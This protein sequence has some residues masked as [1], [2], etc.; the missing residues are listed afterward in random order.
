MRA[1]AAGLVTAALVVV[2][3]IAESLTERYVSDHSRLAGS[4]IELTI[5]ALAALA[6]S[7]LHKRVESLIEAAFTKRR[8]EAREALSHLKRELTSFNDAQQVL[9]RVVEA[10]DRH[11]S[12][13]GCAIYLRRGAYAVEASSF[14]V[15]VTNLEPDDPLV[16]RLRSSSASANPHAINS[17]ASGELAFPMMAGGELIGILTLTPNRI[18]YDAEDRHAL[19]ALA[20]AAGLALIALDPQ[21]RPQGQP[22]NNLP[23]MLTSFVGRENEVTEI[24]A[25]LQ[26]H[27]LMTLMGAGGVGKTRAALRVAANLLDGFADGVWLVELAPISDPSLVAGAVAQTLNAPQSS[28]RPPID[29]L[30][31]YLKRKRLLLLLD[32]CEH[33]INDARTVAAAVLHGCPEVHIL[34]TSREH[35]NVSGEEVYRMPSLSV[36]PEGQALPTQEVLTFGAALLFA[37]RA[38]AV[39]KRFAI[40]DENAPYVAEISRRLDGIPLAIEL[41]A[42]R[43]NVLSPKQL[44]QKLDERFRVLTGGDRSALPRHQTMRALIDWSYDLLSD[45]ERALFRKLSIFAGGFTL[46][47]ARAVCDVDAVDEIATL[48]LLSSLVDKSLVQA[49]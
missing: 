40:T 22:R 12:A 42:A 23:H 8:R 16:I 39:D 28:D 9:R 32:N 18:D 34:A 33:V 21:L 2:F 25:L 5:V 6:F 14:D 37:D 4:A 13:A 7:P 20:E 31:G 46:E 41:A 38:F 30:V 24:Q 47:S 10:V 26:Q 43:V 49:Q 35:L 3:A 19:D 29:T 48:D 17:A 45:D 36:P 1:Y 11:M 15:P 44:A 27:R